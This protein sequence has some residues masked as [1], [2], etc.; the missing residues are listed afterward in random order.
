MMRV[1]VLSDDTIAEFNPGIFLEKHQWEMVT[2]RSPVMDTLRDLE[3]RRQFEVYFNLCEGWE[4]GAYTGIEVIRALEELN[5]P[6]TGA[7]SRF[8]D[9]S[10]EEMQAIAHENGI[11]FARGHRARGKD[12]LE[13]LVKELHYPLIVKHPQSFASTAMTRESRV[14]N[15]EDLQ[16]QVDRI[17]SEFGSARVEEF[18]EGREFTVLVVDN[19]DDLTSPFVYPPGELTF[20]VGENFLHSDVKWN[21]YVYINPLSDPWLAARLQDIS[22][23][24][25]VAMNGRGYGR[26]DIRM[27]LDGALNML[28]INPNSGILFRPEE[29]GPTDI[30]MDFDP[31]G[32]D[33]FL[34]RIFRSALLRHQTHSARK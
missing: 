9:P 32:H 3:S 34:D 5:L 1:C 16:M 4:D 22:R 17:S 18:I 27:G 33:G 26:C 15:F 31:D 29:L 2:M 21:E 7:D 20:P 30:L 10:R 25:F 14:A 19:P 8:F 13:S 12:D 24:L 28:E 6:F 11:T 23:T